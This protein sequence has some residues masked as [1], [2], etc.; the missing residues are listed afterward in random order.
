MRHKTARAYMYGYATHIKPQGYTSR[1]PLLT[2]NK[3]F[4]RLTQCPQPGAT[5]QRQVSY[6]YKLIELQH[7][8]QFGHIQI[9]SRVAYIH[10]TPGTSK[11]NFSSGRGFNLVAS[12]LTRGN[13]GKQS[14]KI[15]WRA[16][17]DDNGGK[18][19]SCDCDKSFTM[20]ACSNLDVLF[21]RVV[22]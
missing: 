1:S 15:V 13:T 4:L 8:L 6:M 20:V 18:H 7:Q 2:T 16:V 21:A 3:V 17:D 9:R 5:T 11:G 14:S 10:P 12:K 19:S 22:L